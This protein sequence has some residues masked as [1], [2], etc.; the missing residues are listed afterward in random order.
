MITIG[1]RTLIPKCL[2]DFACAVECTIS[3]EGLGGGGSNRRGGCEAMDGEEKDP[4]GYSFQI[5]A[6]NEPGEIVEGSDVDE[7]L[8]KCGAKPVPFD[9]CAFLCATKN[10]MYVRCCTESW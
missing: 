4:A 1:R 3:E 2:A 9:H 10:A 8:G 7:R 6:S 5:G